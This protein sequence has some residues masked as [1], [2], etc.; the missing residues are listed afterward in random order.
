EIGVGT[1]ETDEHWFSLDMYDKTDGN[2]HKFVIDVS[3]VDLSSVDWV[4]AMKNGAYSSGTVEFDDICYSTVDPGDG[5]TVEHPPVTIKKVYSEMTEGEDIPLVSA[6]Q[7]WSGTVSTFTVLT[8]AG[9]DGGT[10]VIQVVPS[11]AGWF[12]FAIFTA[13]HAEDLSGFNYLVVSLRSTDI[14]ST[15][16]Q[17]GFGTPA[18]D[19]HWYLADMTGK[20][21][22]NW[23]QFV[24]DV[25]SANLASMEWAFAML[26]EAYTGGTVDFDNVYYTTTAP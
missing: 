18:T 4:F 22:G 6:W 1:P 7:V 19:E 20:T 16:V 5:E 23:H 9:V 13:S 10:A 26:H 12:G 11:A 25:S 21:D 15:A 2:W 14:S 24:I 8:D 17:I 3:A